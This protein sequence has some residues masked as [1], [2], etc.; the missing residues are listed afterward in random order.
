[1]PISLLVTLELIRFF[2]GVM[3]S[4]SQDKLC[5]AEV[6]SSNLNEEL[7]Q[8][9]YVL[10]DKTGTLTKNVMN[11]KYA[12]VAGVV[13]GKDRSL[14]VEAYPRVQ[15]VDFADKGLFDDL[16]KP[17]MQRYLLLLSLCHNVLCEKEKEEYNASSPDELAFVNFAK[18]CG[19]KFT[20]CREGVVEV[21]AQNETLR[22]DLL[23]TLE[24]TSERKRM[25][26]VL[27]SPDNSVRVFCKGADDVLKNRLVDAD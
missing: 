15:N 19:Y 11:F 8:V 27:R 6:Q 26:V 14:E 12:S 21:E 23:Y 18:F 1:M 24:F 10:S 13:Y 4:K 20:G 5:R 2:Q 17:G 3:I 25:S 9:Q 7:G 16:R 22:F